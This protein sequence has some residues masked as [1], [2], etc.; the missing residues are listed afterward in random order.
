L[1]APFVGLVLPASVCAEERQDLD[2]GLADASLALDAEASDAALVGADGALAGRAPP[3][4]LFVPNVSWPDDQPVP[5]AGNLEVLVVVE[6]DGQA[7]LESCAYA[8]SVCDAL[9]AALAL[10]KF[11]PASLN[12]EASAARVQVRF[13]LAQPAAESDADAQAEPTPGADAATKQAPAARAPAPSEEPETYGAVARLERD[14]P[15]STAIELEEVRE[16][17]GALGDPFR[18][19][20]SLPGVVP[21]MTGLPY[22]YV[23]GAPPAATAYFYDDIQLPALFHLA[24]G[25]AV[26]H[27]AMV[28][29]IDF[30]P[31]VAPARYG[32]KTGGVV[33]GKAMLRELKPGVHGELELRLIDLQAYLATPIR[34]TGRFEVAGRYGY[35]GLLAITVPLLGIRASY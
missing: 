7:H 32:R 18:V 12:G 15:L 30:Y 10:S 16:L 28:G 6:R 1:L 17:P 23:R 21:V 4:A 19:I 5:E 8:T 14:K 11:A 9:R 27:P 20:D 22:V 26:V 13:K 3:R 25:P 29:G 34:K 2:A 33:A 31:G 35:P 24:L